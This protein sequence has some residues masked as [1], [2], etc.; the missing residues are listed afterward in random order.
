M[1]KYKDFDFGIIIMI[2]LLGVILYMCAYVRGKNDGFEKGLS[3]QE[4]KKVYDEKLKDLKLHYDY[5]VYEEKSEAYRKGYSDC[6]LAT[7]TGVKRF[8]LME[9]DLSF[10]QFSTIHTNSSAMTK[11]LSKRSK[12]AVDYYKRCNK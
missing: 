12:M 1:L 2:A 6:L 11:Y 7:K 9:D 8:K 5:I 3:K 10:E 4:L